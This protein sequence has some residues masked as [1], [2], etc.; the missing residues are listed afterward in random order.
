MSLSWLFDDLH[1]QLQVQQASITFPDHHDDGGST[2]YTRLLDDARLNRDLGNTCGC[3]SLGAPL[4]AETQWPLRTNRTPHLERY[5]MT[6]TN[7]ITSNPY[8]AERRRHRGTTLAWVEVRITNRNSS[9]L[10]LVKSA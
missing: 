1:A 9:L 4:L 7:M 3:S 5:G 10:Q 6:E 2:F 8:D